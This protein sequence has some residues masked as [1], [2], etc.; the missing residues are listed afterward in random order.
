MEQS[1]YEFKGHARESFWQAKSFDNEE[2]NRLLSAVSAIYP[3]VISVNLTKNNYYMLQYGN[4]TTTQCYDAGIFD[5][6]IAQ[7]VETFH[8]DDRETFLAAFKRE[9]LL[10]AH[11]R[12]E[13]IVT[14]EG[15]Q[16]GDDGIYHHIRTDVIFVKDHIGSDVLQITLARELK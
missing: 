13:T 12:G 4:Y 11:A 5:E 6:L 16:L 1:V 15:R 2:L 8:P 14:H 7:G 3:M 10:S 9:N